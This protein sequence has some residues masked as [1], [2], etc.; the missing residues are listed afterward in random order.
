MNDLSWRGLTGLL[1]AVTLSVSCGSDDA[2]SDP[3]EAGSPETVEGGRCVVRLHGKGASGAPSEAG[4]GAT[5]INPD[6]NEEGWGGRQWLY[7]PD[8]RYAEAMAVLEGVTA[9]CEQVIVHG[10]SNGGAFAAKLYCRGESFDG[11]LVRVVVDDPVVDN[12]VNDCAP[13]P[14]VEVALYWTG[15]L[16][17]PATPGWDCSEM[18]WTCEGGSTIGI[19]AYASALMTQVLTSPFDSH[20]WYLDAPEASFS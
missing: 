8:D 12:A 10:F 9:P 13:D 1:A 18:D 16:D 15:A 17:P 19:D 5:I 14:A 11:R 7:F 6:G 4:A 3:S 20:T 2:R